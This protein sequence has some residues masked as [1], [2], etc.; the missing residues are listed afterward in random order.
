MAYSALNILV[1]ASSSRAEKQKEQYF[2]LSSKYL[3]LSL[4]SAAVQPG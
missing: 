3:G 1:L 4:G 2:L